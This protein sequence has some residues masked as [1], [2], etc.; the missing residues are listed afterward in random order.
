MIRFAVI[1]RARDGLALSASMD[2]DSGVELRDSKRYAKVLS[3]KARHF[4]VRSIVKVGRFHVCEMTEADVCFLLICEATYANVLSFGFLLDLKKEFL[5]QY[6]R[7]AVEQAVRPYSFIEFDSQLQKLK[8]RYNTAARSVSAR[9]DIVELSDELKNNPPYEISPQEL[10]GEAALTNSSNCVAASTPSI[11]ST[12]KLVTLS[13]FASLSLMMTGLCAVMNLVR[14]VPYI[15]DHDDQTSWLTICLL[16]LLSAI[17]N[18]LQC[19]VLLT[20]LR[21]RKPLNWIFATSSLLLLYALHES[22]NVWQLT[23]HIAANVLIT[24]NIWRRTIRGKPSN[25]NV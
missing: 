23:F 25:Y 24:T 10:V 3:K 9:A 7:G 5:T 2:L 14:I 16:F 13:W 19:Y 12:G 11:S 17:T 4:P 18:S 21:W 1:H 8:Q 15:S 22:R 6:T 20:A